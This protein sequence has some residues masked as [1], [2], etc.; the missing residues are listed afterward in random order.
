MLKVIFKYFEADGA[1]TSQILA[2]ILTALI[3]WVTL[4]RDFRA[5]TTVLKKEAK[6]IAVV[7]GVVTIVSIF[8]IIASNAYSNQEK[9]D[10]SQ[11]L[12]NF[13]TSNDS[14]V[15]ISARLVNKND[16]LR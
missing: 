5:R 14:L 4:F 6:V 12:G 9:K 7:V 15:K 13:Q 1:A 8:N 10:V 2:S 16:S 3:S 11:K